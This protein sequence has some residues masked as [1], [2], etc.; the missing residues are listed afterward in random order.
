VTTLKNFTDALGRLT[1]EAS[2]DIDNAYTFVKQGSSNT[3]TCDICDTAGE[4]PIGVVDR[5]YDDGDFCSIIYAGIVTVRAGAAVS[6]GAKIAT[7]ASGRAITAT[8]AH[9]WQAGIALTAASAAGDEISAFLDIRPIDTASMLGYGLKVAKLDIAHGDGTS[10]TDTEF[11]LP[12]TC[13]VVDVLTAVDVAEATGATKTIDIGT[14]STDSGDADGFADALS[15]AATGL[16][17]PQAT[18]TAGNNET[19]YSANTR[20]VLLSDYLVGTDADGDFGL[21]REKPCT[22]PGSVSV[23]WTPGSADFA[24]LDATIYIIYVELV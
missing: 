19:Y 20:G 23:T 18:V 16:V 11:D 9:E 22:A 5:N 13:M 17:R 3:D 24:E 14:L 4:R 10:E 6:S 2:E 8:Y 7:D 21:Y 15:V 12:A 1:L